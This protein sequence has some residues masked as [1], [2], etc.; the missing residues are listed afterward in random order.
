MTIEPP[1]WTKRFISLLL[2]VISMA[3]SK[4]LPRNDTGAKDMFG[5]TKKKPLKFSKKDEM[6]FDER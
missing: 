5:F 3:T 1:F 2:S 6:D 4:K